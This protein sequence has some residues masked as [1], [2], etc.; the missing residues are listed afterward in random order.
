[1]KRVMVWALAGLAS[2]A[3]VGCSRPAA[4][5]VAAAP[6]SNGTTLTLPTISTVGTGK[7]KTAPD[8]L[9]V[10]IGVSTKRANAS[11]ALGVNNAETHTLI[12]K[13]RAGGVAEKDIQTTD[14]SIYP[15]YDNGGH[16][17]GYQV[18]NTVTA[19]MRDLTKAGKTIDAAA[20]AVG[21]DVRIQGISFGI[22]DDTSARAQARVDAV[23]QARAQAEQMAKAAGVS[24]GGVRTMTEQSTES[25]PVPM[26]A[27]AAD[28]A[29][30]STPVAAGQVSL[31]V[32]VS[33]TFDI[34]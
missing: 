31:T 5:V 14:I 4:K 34:G 10:T 11:D 18:N 28:T 26:Y 3:L 32:S 24:L 21:N 30:R 19:V 9:T 12:G 22:S 1:M 17:D 16:I 23:K 25:T 29:L 15:S 7:V 8:M 33:V 6:N 2:V 27:A 20:S 13:L